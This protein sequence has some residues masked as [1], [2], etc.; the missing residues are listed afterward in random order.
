MWSVPL[1]TACARAALACPATIAEL[2]PTAGVDPADPRLRGTDLIVVFKEARAVA[3]YDGGRLDTTGGAPGCWRAALAS[4]YPS[5]P[6]EVRGD[7]K[8][9]EGW[10]RTS[11]RPTSSFYHA[12]N[13]HYPGPTDAA[14][15]LKAGL[16][17]RAQHDAI[18]RAAAEDRMPSGDTHLGG[19]ILLHGGGSAYDWTLGCVALDDAD[20]DA[21]RARLPANLHTDVLILP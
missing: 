5:G 14:R 15:G 7:M 18:V 11:D 2:P 9:P 8:T 4:D 12:L 21:L 16:I 6:K 17:T 19:L 13:V 3:L 20:I 10:Y 1:L